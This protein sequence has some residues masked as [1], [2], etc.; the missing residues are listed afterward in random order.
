MVGR[1]TLTI[2]RSMTVMRNETASSEKARQR[3]TCPGIAATSPRLTLAVRSSEVTCVS[4]KMWLPGWARAAGMGWRGWPSPDCVPGFG[5]RPSAWLRARPLG[6]PGVDG[7]GE[8]PGGD[9]VDWVG[10]GGGFERRLGHAGRLGGAVPEGGV[11]EEPGAALGVVDDS[12]F[13]ERGRR[14]LAGEHLF[15]E[16][17]EV[18]DV[19]DDG[20]GDAS[21]GVAGDGCV[22]EL[23]AED[24]RG[25]DPVVEAGDD[26]HLGGGRAKGDRGVG[27]GELLVTLEQGGD[28]S[29]GASFLQVSPAGGG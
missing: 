18:G 8:A 24:D 10:D 28:P 6:V 2:V 27:A 26:D 22:A 21:P 9:V 29:H 14:A 4:N 5:S 1:A 7:G 12:D 17:G 13:E 15:G 25:V 3:R 16:E 11:G 19:V 20:L 23:E